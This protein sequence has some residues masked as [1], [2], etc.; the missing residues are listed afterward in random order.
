MQARAGTSPL[1][2]FPEGWYLVATRAAIDGQT[3]VGKTW[4]GER[5]VAWRGADGRVSV[6]DATCPHLGSDLGP[7]AGGRVRDG[8]LVCPFHG[9]EYDSTGQCV[10]TPYAP[11]PPTAGLNL[12]ETREFEGLIFAWHGIGGR[13]PQWELPAPDGEVADWCD[14]RVWSNR[15]RGHPQEITENAI[16]LAH[17]RYLHGYDAVSKV[18]APEVDGARFRFRFDFKRRHTVA[19]IQVFAY[20]ATAVIDVHGLGY[21]TAEIREHA[22]GID[23]RLWLLAT[24]IDGDSVELTLVSRMRRVR[25]PK[26]PIVGMR[27]LPARPRTRLLNRTVIAKLGRD[28]MQDAL[29]WGR[30]RYRPRPSLCRS[31]GPIGVYRRYCKQFYPDGRVDG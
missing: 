9:F 4:L 2:P 19:G 17:L 26:R 22:I 28:S 15:I 16:D 12:L 3:L 30:K 13:G 11:P 6:A 20:H 24:P 21:S 14:T 1:Q 23:T 31:D 7:E 8:R 27:F 10:A 5:I 18:G 25:E 29:I